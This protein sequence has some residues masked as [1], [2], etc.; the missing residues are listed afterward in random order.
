ME[1]LHGLLELQAVEAPNKVAVIYDNAEYTYK[2]IDECANYYSHL[3]INEY[4]VQ[5]NDIVAV[6]GNVSHLSIVAMLAILKAGAAFLPL[7]PEHPLERNI[8]IV[9]EYDVKCI[10]TS[11]EY[12]DNLNFSD[13]VSVSIDNRTA[14][15][16]EVDTNKVFRGYVIFT[17]GSTG[18]PKGVAITHSNI[19]KHVISFNNYIGLTSADTFLGMYSLNVDASVEQIFT[20]L[21]AGGTFC[22]FNQK[23]KGDIEE[24]YKQIVMNR[25]TVFAAPSILLKLFNKSRYLEENPLRIILTGGDVLEKEYI[26]KVLPVI[27]VFNGYGVTEATISTLWYEVNDKDEQIYIGKPISGSNVYILDE[28]FK[29]IP[30]EKIGEICIGGDGV[31]PGYLNNE[32][33]TAKRFHDYKGDRIYLTGD[34]GYKDTNGNIAFCGRKDNQIKIRGF[35]IEPREIE[36]ALLNIGK[37]DDACVIKEN[38]ELVAVIS[39]KSKIDELDLKQHLSKILPAYMIPHKYIHVDQIPRNDMGKVKIYELPVKREEA[40]PKR[41]YVLPSN[42]QAMIQKIWADILK[43]PAES[44]AGDVKFNSLGASSINYMEL[45]TELREEFNVDIEIGDVQNDITINKLDQI[46]NDAAPFEEIQHYELSE[47]PLSEIQKS[48]MFMMG[49]AKNGMYNNVSAFSIKREIDIDLFIKSLREIFGKHR[50]FKSKYI[51]NDK[52]DNVCIVD[53][54]KDYISIEYINLK[55][56]S[57]SEQYKSIS[58]IVKK[59]QSYVFQLCNEALV[60]FQIVKISNEEIIIVGN[61]SHM[62]IDGISWSIIFQ[63]IEDYYCFGKINEMPYDYLDYCIYK[64]KAD[65]SKDKDFWREYLK[66]IDENKTLLLDTKKKVQLL[67][68]EGNSICYNLSDERIKKGEALSVDLG[69]PLYLLFAATLHLLLESYLKNGQTVVGITYGLRPAGTANLVGVFLN[70]LPVLLE[71]KSSWTLDELIYQVNKSLT[72]AYI[73]S[74]YPFENMVRDLKIHH[75]SKRSPIFQIALDYV[76]ESTVSN[77][78]RTEEILVDSLYSKYEMNIILK[79]SNNRYSVQFEYCN[80]VYTREFVQQFGENFILLFQCI[81]DGSREEIISEITKKI[82]PHEITGNI[83]ISK[84]SE[85]FELQ[86]KLIQIFGDAIGTDQIDETKN[87]FDMGASSLLLVQIANKIEDICKCKVEIADFFSHTNIKELSCFLSQKNISVSSEKQISIKTKNQKDRLNILTK[88][89]RKASADILEI[90][91]NEDSDYLVIYFPS[92]N[93]T[94][95]E[96]GKD[97]FKNLTCNLINNC[98]ISYIVYQDLSVGIEKLSR[99]IYLKIKELKK[100]ILVGW[101]NGGYIAQKTASIAERYGKCINA[102]FL[103]DT[104]EYRYLK[105]LEDEQKSILNPKLDE[106]QFIQSMMIEIDPELDKDPILFDELMERSNYEKQ[107][108]SYMAERLASVIDKD[109]LMRIYSKY[110]RLFEEQVQKSIQLYSSYTTPD[111]SGRTVLVKSDSNVDIDQNLG[112]KN[113]CTNMEV[114]R[115]PGNHITMLANSSVSLISGVIDEVIQ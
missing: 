115:V 1:T 4:Q 23:K 74:V 42:Q 81:C 83:D 25:C 40:V 84:N 96:Y 53:D 59:E 50:I 33:E 7:N 92:T 45:I 85:T 43:I 51:S 41:M 14:N 56:K 68:Y 22:A 102:L 20:I 112:W 44:I 99:E 110:K 78:F 61:I 28:N 5:E 88:R 62:V 80:D 34:L 12:N 75:S 97:V 32:T 77:F 76:D 39:A 64:K 86:N 9:N 2:V 8:Q 105:I 98:S 48:I 109:T 111:F 17:S 91:R 29:E 30:D 31:S 73:H 89:E 18:K 94:T 67:S 46:I 52:G 103:L 15:V 60:R 113:K 95:K 108:M 106:M 55:S 26:D 69:V 36:T 57:F 58:E 16:V 93:G 35:R 13:K 90:K 3:I 114:I 104:Y 79:K 54:A 6:Y 100:L 82:I 10:L 101:C 21:A 49:Y 27:K 72:N 65:S 70:M 71:I 66:Q 11:E 87:F 38:G 63:E 107:V 47:Y 24:I 19:V 37:I